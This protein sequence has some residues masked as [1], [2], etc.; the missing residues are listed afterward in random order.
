MEP[1]RKK[2]AIVG[3]V[4]GI[5]IPLV[6]GLSF[7]ILTPPREYFILTIATMYLVSMAGWIAIIWGS[8]HLA[9][10]KGYSGTTGILLGLV[11]FIGL[12]I[13]L[14]LADKNKDHQ[15]SGSLS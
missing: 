1:K 8:Y 7:I 3:I 12:L 6:I 15:N 14:L 9:K 13:L 11:G 5:I 4:S 10:G 2:K